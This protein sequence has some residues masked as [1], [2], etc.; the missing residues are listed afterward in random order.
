MADL[1]M[2]WHGE[3]PPT[4]RGL[5]APMPAPPCDYDDFDCED[6]T[7]AAAQ[8]CLDYCWAQAGYDIHHLDSAGLE[9]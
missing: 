6:L 2:V 5:Y 8:A 1:L 3:V 9:R 7:P 4:D